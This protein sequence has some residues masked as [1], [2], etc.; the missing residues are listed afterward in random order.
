MSQP[1]ENEIKALWQAQETETSTM[2]LV[3]IRALARNYSDNTRGRL[4]IGIAVAAVE[5]LMFGL[6]AWRAPND[7]LRIG[8]L[9]ILAGVG[10]MTWRIGSKWPSRLPATETSTV[11]LIEFHRA[12]LVQQQTGPAWITLT[13]A[14]IFAGMVVVMFGFQRMRPN[15]F[16]AN[17]APLIG[18]CLVWWVA[19]FVLQRRQARRLAEQIAEMDE[20]RRG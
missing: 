3:A 9:I 1:P 14:P 19:A 16:L 4:W 6:Y 10:W 2:T 5:V 17:A 8:Y 11:A 12:Q 20:L 18:L 7:L 13:A 15:M